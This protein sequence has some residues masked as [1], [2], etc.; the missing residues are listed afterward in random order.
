[1]ILIL[2]TFCQTKNHIK[3]YENIL[4]YDISYKTFMGSKRL[5]IRL[6]EIQGFIKICDGIRYLVLF[7]HVWYDKICDR[8]KK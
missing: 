5:R 4:N 8:I 1:M 7:G 2:E 6:D 3:K